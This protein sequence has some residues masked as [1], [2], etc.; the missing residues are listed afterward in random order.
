M[1][2]DYSVFEAYFRG[3]RDEVLRKQSSYLPFIKE[4]GIDDQHPA[5]DLACGRGEWLELLRDNRLP[6]EGVEINSDFAE[7]CRLK[8]LAV[9]E[10]DLFDFLSGSGKLYKLITGFHIIEHLQFEK[11][12][13]LLE[14]VM[15][16]LAPGGAV[17]LE[18]PNP[19][20]TAVGCCN[21]FMDPTHIRPVPPLFL[22]YLASQAGFCTPVIVRLNRHTVGTSLSLMP[23]SFLGAEQVNQLVRLVSSQLQQAPDYAL[24]AFRPPLP[25]ETTV[26]LLAVMNR[27][28]ENYSPRT[29]PS[30]DEIMLSQRGTLFDLF[31]QN[32]EELK[33]AR[34]EIL[35][36]EKELLETK[37]AQQQNIEELKT[38]RAIIHQL[39]KER[40]DTFV[41]PL[42]QNNEELNAAKTLIRQLEKELLDTK[43]VQQHTAAELHRSNETLQETL[44]RYR[45]CQ[46]ELKSVYHTAAGQFVRYYKSVR[47]KFK[48]KK[49]SDTATAVTPVTSNSSANKTPG[50][51]ESV[52]PVY[53]QLLGA[54]KRNRH[55]YHKP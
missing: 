26:S 11:Q 22:E 33:A 24:V 45:E 42:R 54:M 20:N 12:Q 44:S 51:P 23:E 31:R 55:E 5:L 4:L 53:R 6:A 15:E 35:Q 29:A 13:E 8:G 37:L 49:T 36:L 14:K 40:L 27:E 19:E 10:G 1:A 17:L 30:E 34:T 16:N 9:K 7:H 21:F 43:T 25:P 47:K 41:E 39:E 46:K 38:A 48:K 52:E 32:N 50:Y 2:F 18:T 28:T 3:S